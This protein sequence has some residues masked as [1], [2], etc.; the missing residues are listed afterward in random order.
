MNKLSFIF[1]FWASLL[2]SQEVLEEEIEIILGIDKLMKIDFL[3]STKV[4]IADPSVVGVQL[5]PQKREI[6]IQGK[7]SGRSSITFR[8]QFGNIKL[9]YVVNIT[10]TEKSK[11]IQELIE[12]IGDVEGLEIG[13]KGNKV[14]VG[15]KII[16]PGDIGKIVIILEQY[17]EVLNLIEVSPQTYQIVARKMQEGLRKNNLRDVT[18]RFFNNSYILEGII[19]SDAQEKLAI[20]IAKAYLPDRIESLA[21]RT[22]SVQ[23]VTQNEII[24]N[25]LVKNTRPPPP[26]IKKLVKITAQFVELAKDYNKIFGF[27]WTPTV[28]GGG[29]SIAIGRS[30]SGGIT[31]KSNGVFSTTIGQLFPKLNSAKAAGRAR[32]IQSGIIIVTD[33]VKGTIK[34]KTNKNTSVGTNEFTKPITLSAGFDL[35]VEP[36]VLQE[37]KISLK[38]SLQVSSSVDKDVYTNDISTELIIKSKQSAVIGG[39]SVNKSS[40]EYDK[41]PP[42]GV[43]SVGEGGFPLFSFLRSKEIAR[44]K[45]QFVVFITP[46]I[47]ENASSGTEGIKRK[48]RRRGY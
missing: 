7:K 6:T 2:F 29:G 16:V 45:E 23:S 4:Q 19:N 8:D 12:L 31:T 32:V 17:K 47:I 36:R 39:V 42:G 5:I 22:D 27:K 33:G 28:S 48:F 30:T 1:I 20:D 11:I 24:K 35:G 40:T 43:D 18:V 34:R 13:L 38:V 14:Y 25:F 26:Q 41:D 15:G 21:R 46:E 3:P 37:E 10:A 44:S 9:R